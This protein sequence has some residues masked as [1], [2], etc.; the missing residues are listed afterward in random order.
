[1]HEFAASRSDVEQ[2]R[3]SPNIFVPRS[4]KEPRAGWQ[5]QEMREVAPPRSEVILVYGFEEVVG[6]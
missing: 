5:L 2:A 3:V 6:T 4:G 1:M